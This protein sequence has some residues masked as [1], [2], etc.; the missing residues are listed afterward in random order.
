MSQQKQPTNSIQPHKNIKNVMEFF[1]NRKIILKHIW[2][3]RS[4]PIGK[5][6][7]SKMNNVG[8]ITISDSPYIT[9]PS[10]QNSMELA[11]KQTNQ[12]KRNRLEYTDISPIS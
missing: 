9:K 11:Q 6:S 10:K 8:N 2:K 3:C 4:Y 1:I 12:S 5:A 7:L